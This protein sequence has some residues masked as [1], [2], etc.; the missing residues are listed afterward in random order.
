MKRNPAW[1]DEIMTAVEKELSEK[2]GSAPMR[3]PMSA[4]I[5]QAWK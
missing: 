5:S 3:A 2:Y 4:I 1:M